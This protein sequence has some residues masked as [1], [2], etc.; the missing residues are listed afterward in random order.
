MTIYRNKKGRESLLKTTSALLAKLPCEGKEHLLDTNSGKAYCLELGV[1]GRPKIVLVHGGYTNHS[2]ILYYLRGLIDKFHIFA[3]DLPG[4]PG[5]SSETVLDPRGNSYGEWLVEVV[6]KLRIDKATFLGL[7]Y[8][9]FVCQRLAAIKPEVVEKVIL[10]VSAGLCSMNQISLV[11]N[12]MF[13]QIFF[14]L[15]KK[16]RFLHKMMNALFTDYDDD[17]VLDFFRDM[18]LYVKTDQRQMRLSRPE[19]FE[20]FNN[21]VMLITAENDVVFD[22]RRQ[23]RAAQKLFSNIECHNLLGEKHSPSVTEK[24]RDHVYKLITYFIEKDS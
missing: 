9:G 21:P 16:E 2:F 13:P 23:T 6:D 3:I 22:F 7:S 20:G 12:L 5:K 15:T 17:L 1:K 14:G 19:E 24:G 8:G 18:L 4:H 11:K 10:I